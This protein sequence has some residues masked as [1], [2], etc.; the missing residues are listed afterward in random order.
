MN[1]AMKFQEVRVKEVTVNEE[2]IMAYLVDGR[3]I[4]VPLV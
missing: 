1:T 2:I 4:S 3:M